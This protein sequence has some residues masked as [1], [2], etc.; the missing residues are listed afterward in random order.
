MILLKIK[1]VE[2]DLNVLYF[3]FSEATPKFKKW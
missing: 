1:R 2:G 3:P